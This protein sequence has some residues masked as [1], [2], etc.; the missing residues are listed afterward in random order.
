MTP[1]KR[2]NPAEQ[3]D[4]KI[5]LTETRQQHFGKQIYTQNTHLRRTYVRKRHISLLHLPRKPNRHRHISKDSPTAP[6]TQAS[7]WFP[8]T[9]GRSSDGGNVPGTVPIT[10]HTGP[11][12]SSFLTTILT[13]VLLLGPTVYEKL[14]P[15][16]KPSGAAAPPSAR[17]RGSASPYWR[18]EA[19]GHYRAKGGRRDRRRC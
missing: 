16:W 19:E 7:R 8:R 18:M 1:R 12:C 15:P 11:T 10:F 17:R 6:N 2:V 9:T 13:E 4:A 14:R 5:D 3:T